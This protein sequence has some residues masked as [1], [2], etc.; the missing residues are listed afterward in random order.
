MFGK[1]VYYPSNTVDTVAQMGYYPADGADFLNS[2]PAQF[3]F[4]NFLKEEEKKVVII[5]ESSINLGGKCV[6]S[7]E[8]QQGQGCLTVS[9]LTKK[10]FKKVCV[11]EGT[12]GCTVGKEQSLVIGFAKYLSADNECS[13]RTVVQ[14]KLPITDAP[15]T[16]TG[17]PS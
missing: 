12:I 1:G 9:D 13:A 7:N 15:K 2:Q 14:D 11:Y 4:K 17:A 16:D 8:C 10:K 3:E 6:S 5:K